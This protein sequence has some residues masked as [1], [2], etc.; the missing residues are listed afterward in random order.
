[1]EVFIP[2]YNRHPIIPPLCTLVQAY[3]HVHAQLFCYTSLSLCL[4]DWLNEAFF[5]HE[6]ISPVFQIDSR[7][8]PK[9][10]WIEFNV[11]NICC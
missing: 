10:Y 11:N 3:A 5:G 8:C 9:D 1:M 6:I 7:Q 4:N 2:L